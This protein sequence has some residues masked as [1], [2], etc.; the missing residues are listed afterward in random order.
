MADFEDANSPTW[1]NQ[2]SGH[3]NLVDAIEGTITYDSSDGRHYALGRRD[4]DAAGAPAR[5]A[6]AREAPAR[7]RRAGAP[8]RWST[9]A[10]S[11]STAPRGCSSAGSAPYLYLPK[12]EHHLEARLWN[13]VLRVDRGRARPPA[14]ARS[15]R[16]S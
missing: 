1:A 15:A 11:P 13:D 16:R 9:S 6:P 7:R 3:A 10:C 12:L 8:A 4:G 5:L 2:V 14:R